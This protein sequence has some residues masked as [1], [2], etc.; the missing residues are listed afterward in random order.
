MSDLDFSEFHPLDHHILDPY[1]WGWAGGIPR[2]IQLW[3]DYQFM[4][5]PWP[6]RWWH[7]RQCARGNHEVTP[8]WD[9]KDLKGRMPEWD[10]ERKAIKDR[11]SGFMC[12]HCDWRRSM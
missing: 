2:H 12:F 7:R 8:Y 1:C 9:S 3:W 6:L 4:Q 11:A 5:D 10:P